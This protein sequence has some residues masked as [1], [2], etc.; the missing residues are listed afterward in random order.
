MKVVLVPQINPCADEFL[1]FG[2]SSRKVL[3]KKIVVPID[4]TNALAQ[5]Q[6]LSKNKRKKMSYSDNNSE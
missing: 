6:I 3:Y 2:K 1:E 5:P 4:A